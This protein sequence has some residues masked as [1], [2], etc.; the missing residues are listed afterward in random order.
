MV[1]GSPVM[2]PIGCRLAALTAKIPILPKAE[3]TTYRKELSFESAESMGAPP[4]PSEPATALSRARVPFGFYRYEESVP[5]PVFETNATF[6]RPVN[7][8]QHDAIWPFGTAGLITRKVS[9]AVRRNEEAD[10]VVASA[11]TRNHPVRT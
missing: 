6:P 8:I 4:A 1:L 5:L 10:A 9:C 11:T 7:D 3:S 2:P